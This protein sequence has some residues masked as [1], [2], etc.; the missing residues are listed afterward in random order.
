M[1]YIFSLFNIHCM[2]TLTPP[3]P[4]LNFLTIHKLFF[5]PPYRSCLQ[6]SQII[7]LS[8]HLLVSLLLLQS[9]SNDINWII[10]SPLCSFCMYLYI[11]YIQCLL[12]KGFG[13]AVCVQRDRQIVYVYMQCRY[14]QLVRTLFEGQPVSRMETKE[15]IKKNILKMPLVHARFFL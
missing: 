1:F 7:H 14:K 12:R 13:S 8:I 9:H 10:R 2:I 5:L 4:P 11:V 3:P 6:T 15:P